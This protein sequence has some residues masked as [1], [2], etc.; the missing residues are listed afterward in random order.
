MARQFNRQQ[1]QKKQE[2]KTNEMIRTN[3]VRL[4]GEGEP[5]VIE[6]KE[7]L[8]L[9]VEAGKDLIM[10]N[11]RQDPPI[12]KIEDYKKFL[13][14]QKKADKDKKKNSVKTVVKEIKLSPEIGDHDLQTK[15][16]SAIKFLEHGDK[17]KCSLFL[18]GRQ[19]ANPE[20]GEITMLKFATM[21]EDHGIVESVPRFQ[22]NKWS[23]MIKPKKK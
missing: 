7:A 5:T 15:V 18:R 22:S 14:N 11:E 6:T 13:Y 1:P 10:I 21:L 12:V 23:M 19:R 20:R 4:V 2:H 8:K 16:K 17:I 9:A 3:L